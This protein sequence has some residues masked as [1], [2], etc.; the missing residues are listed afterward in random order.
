MGEGGGVQ[1]TTRGAGRGGAGPGEAA[2]GHHEGKL[3]RDGPLL[4]RVHE[5]V[6]VRT[7]RDARHTQEGLSNAGV[8]GGLRSLRGLRLR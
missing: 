6:H 4:G 2:H 7:A 1:P 8:L 5:S 3:V